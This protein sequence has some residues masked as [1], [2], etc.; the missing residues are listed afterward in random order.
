VWG[1]DDVARIFA[2]SAHGDKAFAS[3]PVAVRVC[4]SL[5]RRFQEPLLEIA[6]LCNDGDE[7]TLLSLELHAQ[8]SF[9]PK[10]LLFERLVETLVD[11]TNTVGVDVNLANEHR[12]CAGALRYVAGLG[13]RKVAALLA[14][15]EQVRVLLL[16]LILF[17]PLAHSS[18]SSFF[19]EQHDGRVMKRD[20]LKFLLPSSKSSVTSVTTAE[21]SA[22]GE[23][24]AQRTQK[25]IDCVWR[26]M[27][28]FVRL[29]KRRDWYRALADDDEEDVQWNP[30]D[31]TR[32]HPDWYSIHC[33][34]IASSAI[35]TPSL[36]T[37][38]Q[39]WK[40]YESVMKNCASKYMERRKEF[41]TAADTL[42]AQGVGVA[43]SW[44]TR[45]EGGRGADVSGVDGL[46]VQ[47][48][49]CQLSNTIQGHLKRR[50]SAQA[51]LTTLARCD[52]TFAVKYTDHA[53][54]YEQDRVVSGVTMA[55]LE[56]ARDG[57]GRE[58]D[59]ADVLEEVDL[60]AFECMLQ[61]RLG[62][63]GRNA[64]FLKMCTRIVDEMRRPYHEKRVAWRELSS[65]QMFWY[66]SGE[67][68]AS[69]WNRKRVNATVSNSLQRFYD[70]GELKSVTVYCELEMGARAQIMWSND[71]G[72]APGRGDMVICD[73]ENLE[74]ERYWSELERRFNIAVTLATA[75]LELAPEAAPGAEGRYFDPVGLD[76][77]QGRAS[78]S[79]GVRLL[80][81]NI[82]VRSLVAPRGAAARLRSRHVSVS[83]ALPSSRAH[84]R[85]PHLAALSFSLSA[86][87]RR[88][89]YH[90]RPR[91]PCAARCVPQRE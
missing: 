2:K 85:S 19:N 79:K 78:G 25:Q 8:Q 17:P 75:R 3:H 42:Q 63:A 53:G 60:E 65:E 73:I 44:T 6:S 88:A 9:V 27:V 82:L 57:A 62:P 38:E 50:S 67:S 12:H 46:G 30:L 24:A 40:L 15:I 70:G 47:R 59:D 7:E 64:R 84:S 69:L 5:A 58:E 14:N 71:N 23:A 77:D 61:E 36:E 22:S 48:R 13:S 1:E 52:G 28:G 26:N 72:S 86:L 51:A 80:K 35:E 33:L 41:E 87:T 39:K 4:T 37:D 68:A 81:R 20:D 89:R 43:A 21:A 10:S 49:R 91:P 56:D 45:P 31:E 76:L 34:S 90:H 32:I 54:Q 55:Q 83:L 16:F 29:R 74:P 18:L 11:V 66:I